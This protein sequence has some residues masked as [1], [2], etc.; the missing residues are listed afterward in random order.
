MKWWYHGQHSGRLLALPGCVYCPHPP[1]QPP[2]DRINWAAGIPE[3]DIISTVPNVAQPG[4]TEWEEEK[5]SQLSRAKLWSEQ[6][7]ARRQSLPATWPTPTPARAVANK[8]MSTPARL[9]LGERLNRLVASPPPAFVA[10]PLWGDSNVSF[11]IDDDEDTDKG[12]LSVFPNTDS[13]SPST[14]ISGFS[15]GGLTSSILDALEAHFQSSLLEDFGV[16]D[17]SSHLHF[18]VITPAS[19]HSFSDHPRVLRFPYLP[20]R[21]PPRTVAFTGI[22]IIVSDTRLPY[23]PPPP[24]PS[25]PSPTRP[26]NHTNQTNTKK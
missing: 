3:A 23:L 14:S 15:S 19:V 17:D 26:P 8:R 5:A 6:V 2:L 11:V 20:P 25:P 1:I 9:P 18:T 10:P 22:G 16:A 24:L 4:S 21:A 13:L 12:L 7:K